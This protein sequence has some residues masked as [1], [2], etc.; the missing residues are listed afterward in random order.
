MMPSRPPWDEVPWEHYRLMSVAD[1]GLPD[2]PFPGHVFS[3]LLRIALALLL[4]ASAIL[5]T[6]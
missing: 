4:A 6:T 1:F 2:E 3:R 5:L